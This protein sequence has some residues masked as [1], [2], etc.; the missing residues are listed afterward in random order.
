MIKLFGCV[1]RTDRIGTLRRI[2]KIKFIGKR[3]MGQPRIKWFG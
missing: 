1:E 2:L 3:F